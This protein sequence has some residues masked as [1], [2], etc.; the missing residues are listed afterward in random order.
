MFLDFSHEIPTSKNEELTDTTRNAEEK[1]TTLVDADKLACA[2]N[3]TLHGK[4]SSSKAYG[5]DRQAS[6]HHHDEEHDKFDEDAAPRLW[7]GTG[8]GGL[9]GAP[10]PPGEAERLRDFSSS[11]RRW[12]VTERTMN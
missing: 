5:H 2:T 3:A 8:N 10:R 1:P 11:K 12:T 7:A 9:W 6:G 4:K